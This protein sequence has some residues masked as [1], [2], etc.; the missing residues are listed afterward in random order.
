SRQTPPPLQPREAG[1]SFFVEHD[2]FA[3]DDAIVARKRLEGN[4]TFWKA[5][6]LG[7]AVAGQQH[8][9]PA[10]LAGNQAI[11]VE[12]ELEQPAFAGER[13]LANLAVHRFD[14]VRIDAPAHDMILG[15]YD[16]SE[17]SGR[18]VSGFDLLDG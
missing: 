2:D 10:R 16:F 8:R 4:R 17:Q 7:V 13:V 1:N 14:P 3:I 9:L 5:S 6:G 18:T 15:L 11:A 12:L